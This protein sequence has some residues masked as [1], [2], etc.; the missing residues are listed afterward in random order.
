MNEKVQIPGLAQPISL[1][2]TGAT[3]NTVATASPHQLG[4]PHLWVKITISL[5]LAQLK[6]NELITL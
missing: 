1:S 2:L 4:K 6:F 5:H 3:G